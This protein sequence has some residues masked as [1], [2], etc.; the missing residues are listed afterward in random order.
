MTKPK[1]PCPGPGRGQPLADLG[2]GA[3]ERAVLAVARHYCVSFAAPERQGWISAIAA[4][5]EG[6]GDDQGPHVAV[7]TLAVLQT[8]RQAR[9]AG[10]RFNAP[11]C[12]ACAAFVTGHERLL[13]SALRALARDEPEAARAHAM[14][15]CEGRAEQRV[16]DALAILARQAITPE[17][18]VPPR[19]SAHAGLAEGR[20]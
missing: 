7:A 14:L 13:M 18:P 20:A 3:R 5:L 10:F 6:F 19:S 2:Y 16:T 11:D 1:T 17:R 12:P 15:L 9:R 4:A 8:L